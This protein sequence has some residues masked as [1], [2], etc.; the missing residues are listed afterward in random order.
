M[1]N[2][3]AVTN[4]AVVTLSPDMKNGLMAHGYKERLI[5]VIM[6]GVDVDHFTPMAGANESLKD[7]LGIPEDSYIV[8]MA[9]RHTPDTQKCGKDIPTFLR[10]AAVL[11]R[12]FP[13]LFAKTHF[14]ICGNDT[15]KGD[16]RELADTLGIGGRVHILGPRN[17][18]VR[19]YSAW[20][21]SNMCSVRE[22]FGLVAAESMACKTPMVVTNV[23]LLPHIVGNTGI[24]VPVRAADE[25]AEAW[26]KLLS[27]S[28]G[29]KRDLGNLARNRTCAHFDNARMSL[30]FA[31]VYEDLLGSASTRRGTVKAATTAE[32]NHI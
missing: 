11:A 25:R 24:V 21:V 2:F 23:D 14:V 5:K 10:A 27:M 1:S 32:Y 19:Q 26:A 22:P 6:N 29:Q 31:G 15:D 12:K 20:D 28:D 7:E 16:L 4:T 17:D 3:A 8:G 13:A 9:S 30:E 18:M